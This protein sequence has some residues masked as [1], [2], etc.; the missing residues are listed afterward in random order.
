M[1]GQPEEGRPGR[2]SGCD[3]ARGRAGPFASVTVTT[4][5]ASNMPDGTFVVELLAA[6]G[7]RMALPEPDGPADVFRLDPEAVLFAPADHSGRNGV[8]VLYASSQLGPDHGTDRRALVYRIAAT[9]ATR[10]SSL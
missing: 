10:I 4:A 7:A 9:G 2:G 8:L 6:T 5:R 1:R 3:A